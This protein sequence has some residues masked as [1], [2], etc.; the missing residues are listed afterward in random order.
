LS[1]TDPTADDLRGIAVFGSSEP[2]P[3]EPL[4]ETARELGRLLALRGQP[5]VTGGYGGVME[6]ASRGARSAGGRAVGVT[7]RIFG[8][9]AANA[10]VS[11][12]RESDDLF[13]R[14]RE[15]VRLARGFV[16]LEGKA[17]TL[18]ELGSLWALDR[19]GC[20][21]RRPVILLGMRFATLL[22]QLERI[23]LLDREQ[24]E[25]SRLAETPQEAVRLLVEALANEETL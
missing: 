18:A 25:L 22:E 15:L 17:G 13:D 11:D 9:R 14:T 20:L 16:V 21:G 7:C 10:Y 12:M 6:A 24:I 23:D 8:S 19:A 4:Y 2:L 3:G 5:V 1:P